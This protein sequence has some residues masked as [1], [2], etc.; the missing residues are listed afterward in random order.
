M[1][2]KISNTQYIFM[3]HVFIY[4]SFIVYAEQT[5]IYTAGQALR[6]RIRLRTEGKAP[7]E[8]DVKMHVVGI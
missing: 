6:E 8:D 7:I 3:A 5:H 2:S 4:L 1:D